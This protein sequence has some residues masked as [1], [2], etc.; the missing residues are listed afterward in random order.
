MYSRED[1]L[2][3]AHKYITWLIGNEFLKTVYVKPEYVM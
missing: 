3:A 2:Y 1:S